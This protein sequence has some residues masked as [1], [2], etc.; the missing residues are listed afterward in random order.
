[1]KCTCLWLSALLFVQCIPD[2]ICLQCLEGEEEV[3]S[4]NVEI[5]GTPECQMEM[6]GIYRTNYNPVNNAFSFT[7]GNLSIWRATYHSYLIGH[8][9]NMGTN[10]YIAISNTNSMD[11]RVPTTGWQILCNGILQASTVYYSRNKY[12]HCMQCQSGKYRVDLNSLSC[13]GCPAGQYQSAV[14]SALCVTCPVFSTSPTDSLA[15]TAC[16]CNAGY[17]NADGDT[18]VQCSAG[19][20]KSSVGNTGCVGCPTNSMSLE[21]ST[22]STDC[23]CKAGFSGE[24]GMLCTA[25]GTG[26]YKSATGA[27]LCQ[28]CTEFSNSQSASSTCTCNDGYHNQGGQTCTVSEYTCDPISKHEKS[29][30]V[31][32]GTGSE[33]YQNH[34]SMRW[35]FDCLPHSI[36][37]S[38]ISPQNV[39]ETLLLSLYAIPCHVEMVFKISHSPAELSTFSRH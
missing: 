5:Q 16:V 26:K 10:V 22:A 37:N 11:F 28:T 17:Y 12:S 4:D 7:R 33:L 30:I 6:T 8:T 14:G 18:C 36:L 34:T 35:T 19:T 23:L 2:S 39:P 25:C 9:A 15:I 29:G 32:D 38:P 21:R 13:T 1:M 27:G 24:N 3:F 20:Y 31:T